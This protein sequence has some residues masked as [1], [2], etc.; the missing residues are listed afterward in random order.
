M[1]EVAVSKDAVLSRISGI[2]DS[3]MPTKNLFQERLNK[4]ELMQIF[5]HLLEEVS[6]EEL[7][8]LEDE[9]LTKRVK[10]VMVV[11]AT[12]GILNDL[13]PEQMEMFDASVEGR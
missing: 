11:E 12:A 6:P 3:L 13:T 2:V 4:D 8:S 5:S 10:G 1:A 7:L 9:R